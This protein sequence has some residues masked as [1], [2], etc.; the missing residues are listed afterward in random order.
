MRTYTELRNLY[1]KFCKNSSTTNLTQGDIYINDGT[2]LLLG[3]EDWSFLITSGTKDTAAS[4]QF[5]NLAANMLKLKS[6]Y[7]VIS[8]TRYNPQLI[9][10]E[11]EWNQINTD[12]SVTS[13]FPQ[14]YFVKPGTQ[15]QMQV[16][17]Y[18]IPSSTTSGAIVY[19]Y[20]KAVKD[21]TVADYTTGSVASIANGGTAV[22]GTGTSWNAS[23]IGKFIKFTESSSANGG[24]G[25]WYEISA[26]GSTTSI[27]LLN[28]YLGTSIA[29]AT[30]TYTIGSV[31][32][33]PD[34][35]QIVPV[36]Y[37][38]WQY[39]LSDGNNTERA[40][41]YEKQWKENSIQLKETYSNRTANPILSSSIYSRPIINANNFPSG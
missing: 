30:A 23:M 2:K 41:Y 37:A 14:Y 9:T 32:V 20:K 16:G 38:A 10:S 31:S 28:P 4:T 13:D 7:V 15:G 18:P 34:E 40:S 3:N 5:Y 33:L 17:F 8:G 25:L 19:T 12:T 36:Y 6:L 21:L 1:G 39:W 11:D 35:Y 27:T 26:V 22:V 24:D 29:A